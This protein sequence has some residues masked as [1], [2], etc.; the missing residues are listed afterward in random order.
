[1]R[2]SDT[3]APTMTQEEARVD[4]LPHVDEHSTVMVISVE[5]AWAALLDVVEGAFS[6]AGARP[7]ARLLGCQEVEASGPRPLGRGS[8][9][10]GFRV[11]RADRPSELT[12]V[13]HH[14][15]ASYAL[16]FRLE[17]LNDGHTRLRADTRAAFP[18]VKGRLYRALV[19][20]THAHALVT[21]GLLAAVARRGGRGPL[22]P[23]EVL[24]LEPPGHAA[25][26]DEQVGA[27]G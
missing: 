7:V 15:F 16:S 6:F 21:R 26:V 23:D 1:M 27:R 19:V 20:G 14:R 9:I 24:D 17:P 4:L 12:L 22:Q 8:T 11:A 3:P 2:Y 25:E 13:G 10:S 5:R 18:G